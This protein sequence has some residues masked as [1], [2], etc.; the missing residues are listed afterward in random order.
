[1]PVRD[2]SHETYQLGASLQ[3]IDHIGSGGNAAVVRGFVDGETPRELALKLLDPR[4]VSADIRERENRKFDHPN[5]VRIEELLNLSDLGFVHVPD[6]YSTILNCEPEP[7]VSHPVASCSPD[8]DN[9][10]QMRN[11]KTLAEFGLADFF[12]LVMEYCPM[13]LSEHIVRHSRSMKEVHRILT[14]VCAGLT[15]MHNEGI[16]HTDLSIDNILVT[17]E[18]VAKIADFGLSERWEEGITK[19][20]RDP[21]L[22]A[23]ELF[24]GEGDPRSDI[25]SLGLLA[26]ELATGQNLLDYDL[27]D[28]DEDVSELNVQRRFVA[29]CK[30]AGQFFPDERFGTVGDFLE[31]LN[32]I[33]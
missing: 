8:P 29:V 25:Y 15:A 33:W 3:A 1:M 32:K 13:S 6:W 27:M 16:I 21:S 30:Q 5:L 24:G 10:R 11:D 14:E 12:I 17:N 18:G 23:P 28:D 22:A 7:F 4:C 19:F 20:I 9:W 2:Y 31:A 26:F